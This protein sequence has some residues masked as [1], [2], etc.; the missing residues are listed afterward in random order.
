LLFKKPKANQTRWLLKAA[1]HQSCFSSSTKLKAA[2]PAFTCCGGGQLQ[3]NY[4]PAT[5]KKLADFKLLH[6]PQST[7]AFPQPT[8]HNNFFK[9]HSST[10]HTLSL[11]FW[12]L[13]QVLLAWVLF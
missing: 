7:T 3:K 1:F 10:K 6:S 9:S 11:L 8:A 5:F 12:K 4:P 13:M 2:P